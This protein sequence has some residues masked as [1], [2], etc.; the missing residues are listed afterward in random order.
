MAS[1]GLWLEGGGE[2]VG[3][4]IQCDNLLPL[5]RQKAAVT[6]LQ[7]LPV[8]DDVFGSSR[9]SGAFLVQRMRQTLL[10]SRGAVCAPLSRL[11]YAIGCSIQLCTHHYFDLARKNTV[12]IHFVEIQFDMDQASLKAFGT[13]S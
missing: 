11:Y 7:V 6:T 3:Y 2:F 13:M 4:S 8:G 12:T 10:I 1:L 9:L 5:I